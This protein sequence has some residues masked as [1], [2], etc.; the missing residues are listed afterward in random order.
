MI[1]I[2][3]GDTQERTQEADVIMA[4][5]SQEATQVEED[6]QPLTSIDAIAVS[7]TYVHQSY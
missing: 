7:V 6:S 3:E 5:D 1:A 2:S 4:V